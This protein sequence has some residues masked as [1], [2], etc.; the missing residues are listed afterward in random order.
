MP[1][2]E[3]QGPRRESMLRGSR[4]A[5][6]LRGTT[7]TTQFYED[8]GFAMTPEQHEAFHD[9]VTEQGEVFEK[10][11]QTMQST[12]DEYADPYKEAL[13]GFIIPNPGGTTEEK[14]AFGK[15]WGEEEK[16][17]IH[18]PYKGR[19]GSL[20]EIPKSAYGEVA[21]SILD[22]PDIGRLTTILPPAWESEK[23]LADME[24]MSARGN[25]SLRQIDLLSKQITTMGYSVAPVVMLLHRAETEGLEAAQAE[26]SG[27]PGYGDP[28]EGA[29]E[30]YLAQRGTP[31]YKS[32]VDSWIKEINNPNMNFTVRN[33]DYYR[34]LFYEIPNIVEQVKDTWSNAVRTQYENVRQGYEQHLSTLDT[35]LSTAETEL[36]GYI[37][38]FDFEIG[39]YATQYEEELAQRQRTFEGLTV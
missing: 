20:G 16:L 8:Y 26:E 1:I 9:T 3:R 25:V 23:L 32:T 30:R 4:E 39:A 21:K 11:R 34:A 2:E 10:Q 37:D 27:G 18:V 19:T 15:V 5:R 28:H 6:E 22:A 24:A 13:E 14:E 17:T 29:V 36:Q 35:E 38:E 33:S 12:Y 7:D 31:D